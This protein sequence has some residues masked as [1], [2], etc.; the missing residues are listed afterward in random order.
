MVVF[1]SCLPTI[2]AGALEP[3]SDEGKLYDTD[4][5]RSLYRPQNTSWQNIAEDLAEEGVGVSMFLGMREFI[6]VGSIGAVAHSHLFDFV[7]TQSVGVVASITGG[8]L[9]FHP[10]FDIRRDGPIF[11]SQ[12][13]RLVSRT[14]GY[15]C[16]LRVRCSDGLAIPLPFPPCRP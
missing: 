15:S 12:I 16:A 7:L 4:K 3:R 14:T 11:D 2:G 5:E 9:F 8:E 6:D 1:Q 10:R 13:R